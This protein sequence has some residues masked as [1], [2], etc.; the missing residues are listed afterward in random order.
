MAAKAGA[1]GAAP[2]EVSVAR[3]CV[4]VKV[5]CSYAMLCHVTKKALKDLLLGYEATLSLPQHVSLTALFVFVTMLA[6]MYVPGLQVA[7]AFSGILVVI[8]VAIFPGIL[9]L[10]LTRLE[11]Q[12]ARGMGVQMRGVSNPMDTLVSWMLILFGVSVGVVSLYVE[13]AKL[14][15]K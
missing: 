7:M 15:N 10:E 12:A 5:A 9:K 8:M 1:D 3:L 14:I 11:A 2:L 6:A 13:V 4:A